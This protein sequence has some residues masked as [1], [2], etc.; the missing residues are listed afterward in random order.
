[1]AHDQ[2]R[3]PLLGKE[4]DLLQ[5]VDLVQGHRLEDQQVL[6]KDHLA[7]LQLANLQLAV[8]DHLEDQGNKKMLRKKSRKK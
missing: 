6:Q 3:L 8:Q 2:S 4:V 1:M 7:N 5:D